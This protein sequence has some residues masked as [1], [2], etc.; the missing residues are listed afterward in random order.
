MDEG[1]NMARVYFT[2]SRE[3]SSAR[4]TEEKIMLLNERLEL[5]QQDLEYILSNLDSENMTEQEI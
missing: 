4:S 3:I 1:E 5:L 2:P